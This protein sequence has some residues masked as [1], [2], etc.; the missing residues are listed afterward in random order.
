[1][2]GSRLAGR[3]CCSGE[4]LITVTFPGVLL[5]GAAFIIQNFGVFGYPMAYC[6]RQSFWRGELPLW[7]P[8]RDSAINN[9]PFKRLGLNR[10]GW[11]RR[12]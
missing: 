7:N 12:S 2:S 3:H 1:M 10:R 4:G 6:H 5:G 9:S 11:P 8:L